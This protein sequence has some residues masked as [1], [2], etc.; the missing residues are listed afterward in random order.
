[1][2]KFLFVFL[3]SGSLLL[4]GC[5]S[6]EETMTCS[7]TVNRNSISMDMKYTV[8]YSGKNVT[9][10][11]TV[12]KVVS[13]DKSTLDF[14]KSKLDQSYEDY[15]DIQYYENEVSIDGNTLTSTTS[16]DYSKIDTDKLIEIDS[17]N[18]KLIEDGKI[19]IDTIKSYY[20]SLGITCEK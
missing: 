4:T 2:K 10:I 16:I 1:M 14:Y 15:K 11:D 18:K 5:N 6:K 9:K 17:S 3:M 13:D 19:N 20:E 12:E 7:R 8:K